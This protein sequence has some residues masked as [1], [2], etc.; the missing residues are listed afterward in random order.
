MQTEI[1]KLNEAEQVW[2]CWTLLDVLFFYRE[3]QKYFDEAQTPELFEGHWSEIDSVRDG[4]SDKS[5]R[6]RNSDDMTQD[7]R[8]QDISRLCRDY[9]VTAGWI[10]AQRKIKDVIDPQ[11]QITRYM[12]QNI[13][14]LA[15]TMVYHTDPVWLRQ[16]R[17]R[18][19]ILA[20]SAVALILQLV[21]HQEFCKN[22]SVFGLCK[23]HRSKK[24]ENLYQLLRK[25]RE[26]TNQLS[27]EI[28]T[29]TFALNGEADATQENLR[30]LVLI[31]KQTFQEYKAN[32]VKCLKGNAN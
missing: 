23:G 7:H 8:G 25:N 16:G 9:K 28:K 10:D 13:F 12:W 18:A 19:P 14:D 3:F 21:L 5:A 22:L 20:G 4:F 32:F 1:L 29:A 2:Y 11:V 26:G 27:A 15:A 6:S 24:V 31:P 30:L 17:P